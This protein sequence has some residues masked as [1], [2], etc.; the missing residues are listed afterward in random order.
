MKLWLWL[1][2]NLELWIWQLDPTYFD[3]KGTIHWIAFVKASLFL[4]LNTQKN[5]SF[6]HLRSSFLSNRKYLKYL[7]LGVSLNYCH[8]KIILEIKLSFWKSDETSSN[9]NHHHHVAYSAADF[10]DFII[11]K[12]HCEKIPLCWTNYKV[13]VDQS[14]EGC[15]VDTMRLSVGSDS[16]EPSSDN[17]VLPS[18][19]Q[20]NQP[21]IEF[22][23]T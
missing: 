13:F 1:N 5:I 2:Y 14:K 20:V 18:S 19:S 9:L 17:V 12:S 21:I 15:N 4:L 16:S 11:W 3:I 23:I 8:I 22:Q 7:F 6:V 10:L